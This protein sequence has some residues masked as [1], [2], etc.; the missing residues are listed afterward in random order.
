M[1]DVSIGKIKD[2]WAVGKCSELFAVS[3]WHKKVASP[4]LAGSALLANKIH[5]QFYVRHSNEST[6]NLLI[7]EIFKQND[8]ILN[9][10]SDN[11][12]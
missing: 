4:F 1:E 12:L 11:R 7:Q 8:L 2:F 3:C 9:L 6:C 5:L 10:T